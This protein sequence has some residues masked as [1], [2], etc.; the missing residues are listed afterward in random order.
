MDAADMPVVHFQSA[1]GAGGA[2]LPAEGIPVAA[3]AATRR[4][5]RLPNAFG[6]F[7]LFGALVNV[8]VVTL[9]FGYWL[10]H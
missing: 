8:A 7:V 3:V 10:V 9:L 2:A 6:W 5:R 4:P 1:I